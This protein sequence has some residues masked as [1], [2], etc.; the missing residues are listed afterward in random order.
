MNLCYLGCGNEGKHQLKNGKWCC[1]EKWQQ[2][3]ARRKKISKA[4]KGQIPWTKGKSPSEETRRK[5]SEAN[6]GQIPWT[7]GKNHSEETREKMRQSKLGKPLSEEHIQKLR[8][9]HKGQ[10][11]WNTNKKWSKEIRQKMSESHLSQT[12]WNKGKRLTTKELK[13]KHPFAFTIEHIEDCNEPG[14]FKVHCKNHNCPNSK[15]QG[16]FF[17]T[18]FNSQ[19]ANRIHALE[20]NHDGCYLYC[21]DECKN[22]CSIFNKPV[23]QILS[24]DRIRD[25]PEKYYTPEEYS[26][27]RNEVLQ[28]AENECEYCGNLATHAHHSK[29]QKLE[30][31]FALD[32]DYGI[33]C[34]QECHYK[35]GH[36]DECSTGRLANAAC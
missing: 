6:K 20:N 5:L 32:P 18:E 36:T 7:K 12:P 16:G 9:S 17:I 13:E 27:W 26:T 19:L 23:H 24:E 15:E 33:A 34:C 14:K 22:S 4:N 3:P 31:F 35:Y 30:P 10:K 8:D 11:P 2:C 25:D 21:S 29:P 28:R 1:S